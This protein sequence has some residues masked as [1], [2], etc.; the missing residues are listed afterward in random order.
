MVTDA[1]AEDMLSKIQCSQALQFLNE[2]TDWEDSGDEENV[3]ND[4]NIED[5][6]A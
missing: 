4:I 2:W 5:E 3:A 6:E 1:C